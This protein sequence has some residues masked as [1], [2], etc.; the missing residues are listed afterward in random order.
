[1]WGFYA[2]SELFTTKFST[3]CDKRWIKIQNN[4][5]QV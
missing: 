1:M 4:Q 5:V 2:D 3:F